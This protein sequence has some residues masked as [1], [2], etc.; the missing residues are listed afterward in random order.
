MN[1]STGTPKDSLVCLD[2]IKSLYP[3]MSK[4]F[5][6]IKVAMQKDDEALIAEVSSRILASRRKD[7]NLSSCCCIP[8]SKSIKTYPSGFAILIGLT[9]DDFGWKIQNFL[10]CAQYM[11]RGHE[12]DLKFALES[13]FDKYGM[14]SRFRTVIKSFPCIIGKASKHLEVAASTL[15]FYGTGLGGTIG[16]V[17]C[18]IGGMNT[19]D[20]N[21][22]II[23]YSQTKMSFQL[24]VCGSNDTVSV[25]GKIIKQG[26]ITISNKSICSVGSRVFVFILAG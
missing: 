15:G 20:E 11:V 7:T 3:K 4:G 18:N 13:E 10:P 22:A 17:D 16:D 23:S 2:E 1:T 6:G 19:C 14:N 9:P 5:Q 8:V 21:G 25:G 12:E 24:S 26:S